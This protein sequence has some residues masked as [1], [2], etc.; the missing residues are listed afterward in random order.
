MSNM[1]IPAEHTADDLIARLRA[2]IAARMRGNWHSEEQEAFALLKEA[3]DKLSYSPEITTEVL[4]ARMMSAA[5][6]VAREYLPDRSDDELDHVLWTYTGFPEF[7]VL[8][9]GE[10]TTEPALRRQLKAYADDPQGVH[11]AQ[12]AELETT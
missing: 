9:P 7:F 3:A 1:T 8:E 10:T 2:F 5:L 6:E 11:D 4:V 12:Q